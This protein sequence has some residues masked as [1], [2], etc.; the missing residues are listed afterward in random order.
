MNF[1]IKEIIFEEIMED[2]TVVDRYLSQTDWGLGHLK[3]AQHTTMPDQRFWI[4]SSHGGLVSGNHCIASSVPGC[5]IDP[6]LAQD[7]TNTLIGLIRDN[8][9]QVY[10]SYEIPELGLVSHLTK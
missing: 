3:F 10:A 8:A 2:G 4:A 6:A 1:R 7:R 5:D 9:C